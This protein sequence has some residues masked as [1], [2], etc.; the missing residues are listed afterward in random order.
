MLAGCQVKITPDAA[1]E[2]WVLQILANACIN[3]SILNS[4]NIS[5]ISF[6]KATDLLY[7]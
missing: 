4:G 6:I 7:N 3:R 1:K 2:S 5:F